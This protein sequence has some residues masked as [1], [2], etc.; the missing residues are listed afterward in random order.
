MEYCREAATLQPPFQSCHN[1]LR[2]HTVIL[3]AAKDPCSCLYRCTTVNRSK[4]VVFCGFPAPETT[5]FAPRPVNIK[6]EN[7]RVSCTER[8]R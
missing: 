6:N 3:S 4:A 7:A 8:R 5:L 1:L 2:P